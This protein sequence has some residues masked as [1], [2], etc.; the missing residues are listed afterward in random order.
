M[1]EQTLTF[2]DLDDSKSTSFLSGDNLTFANLE[3]ETLD[4]EDEEKEEALSFANLGKPT[5]EEDSDSFTNIFLRAYDSSQRDAFKG[6]KLF[7]EEAQEK[8]PNTSAKVIDIASKGIEKNQKQVQARKAA[9]IQDPISAIGDFKQSFKK[10]D[11]KNAFVELSKDFSKSTADVLGQFAPYIMTGAAATV[12]GRLLGLGAK[13]QTVLGILG[14][15][16]PAGLPSKSSTYEEAL[17][18][19]AS[20]EDARKYSTYA[21]GLSTALGSLL[22]AY[23]LGPFLQSIGR[24][25]TSKFVMKDVTE[26]LSQKMSKEAAEKASKKITKELIDQA[27]KGIDKTVIK[28]AVKPSIVGTAI[29]RGTTAGIIGGATE[30]AQERIQIGAAGLA[31]EDKTIS[32]Y[33]QEEINNRVG[34]AAILGILGDKTLGTFSG[35]V[36]ALSTRDFANEYNEYALN[37]ARTEKY[38]KDETLEEDLVDVVRGN[39]NKDKKGF[40]SFNLLFRESLAPLD[41]FSKKSKGNREVFNSFSN[42]YNNLSQRTGEEGIKI[43]EALK[44]SAKNFKVPLF[45]KAM[46]NKDNKNIYELL[47]NFYPNKKYSKNNL[48]SFEAIR[49]VTG[50]V[51]KPEVSLDGQ[52]LYENII[53]NSPTLAEVDVAYN[54]GRVPDT[55][56][57]LIYKRYNR[58]LNKYNKEKVKKV[59]NIEEDQRIGQIKTLLSEDKDFRKLIDNPIAPVVATGIAKNV[60][61]EGIKFKHQENYF[62]AKYKINTKKQQKQLKE[63]IREMQPEDFGG[64]K[65][66]VAME[67]MLENNGFHIPNNKKLRLENIYRDDTVTDFD[68][69]FQKPRAIKPETRKKLYEAGLTETNLN[70]VLEQYVL[71]SSTRI[72]IAKLSNKF[73]NLI[74]KKRDGDLISKDEMSYLQDTFQALQNNHRPMRGTAKDLQR[75]FITYQ[76]MLTLPTSALTSLTEP[77]VVLSRVRKRDAIFGL[78]ESARNTLRQGLRSVFPKLPYSEKEKAFRSILEGLDGTLAERMGTIAGQDVS[79]KVTD[80]FFKSILLTQVTQFSRDMAYNAGTGQIKV[81]IIDALVD[82]KRG[83]TTRQ[84]LRAKKRLMEVGLTTKAIQSKEMVD[85]VEGRTKQPP[86]LFQKAMAKFVREIIMAP[87]VINRPLWMSNPHYAMLSL[88]KGFMFTFGL[89]VMPKMW[90]ELFKPMITLRRMPVEAAVKYSLMFGLI[91]AGTMG[92]KEIKN[93]IRYGSEG[94][95]E[96]LSTFQK[97]IDAFVKS[98][99]FGPG[100]ILFDASKGYKYGA[101]PLEVIAGPG[102]SQMSS[103]IKAMGQVSEGSFRSISRFFANS[104]PYFSAIAPKK[105]K[106]TLTEST[107]ETLEDLLQ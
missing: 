11:Y 38:L 90:R 76:Y 24:G 77:L 106:D 1:V 44:E 15:T 104:I 43:K 55:D 86:P 19:G 89:T 64:T 73:N 51:V 4:K 21:Y 35:A 81:D 3:G 48:N 33:A 85:F 29:K 47:N 45:S 41:S 28:Q 59:D 18:L 25:A 96:D 8:F 16:I 54:E 84:G 52:T 53:N 79:R 34:N 71:D 75:G 80:R 74:S 13:G 103:L 6:I 70:R 37:K 63:I 82:I 36:E 46:S 91:I 105:I 7:A 32:P 99:I 42:F 62:P 93:Y 23:L 31:G 56:I 72:E 61:G 107:E 14:G 49:D 20:D 12:P 66:D 58:L 39:Y 102:L 40:N 65:A 17:S 50:R 57:D 2:A 69:D 101:S 98:N 26:E 67:N 9:D 10:G 92:I 87:N 94:P 83:K 5:K 95:Y 97:I 30:A 100:T 88:L 68:K 27:E 22:P 78:I 60:M